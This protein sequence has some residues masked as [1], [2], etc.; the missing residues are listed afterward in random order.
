MKQGK[1]EQAPFEFKIDLFDFIE[2]INYIFEYKETDDKGRYLYWD[3]FKY[4]VKEGDNPAIAWWAT[5]F[6][7]VSKIK[8]LPLK[9]KENKEFCF[10]IPDALQAKLYQIMQKANQGIVP[11]DSIKRQYLISSLVIEEAIS[12]SQLEGAVT[13]RKVAKDMLVKERK[14]KSEDEWMILNNYMLLK[15]AKKTKNDNLSIGL[16]REFHQ[17]ATQHT[18][19]NKVVAGE[20]RVT[21][22][23]V[24]TDG[25]EVIFEPPS[26]DEIDI[27]LQELCDFA[28]KNHHEDNL[29]EFINPIVK[30]IILHFMIGYIHP[31]NDGNGRVART[32]FY[33]YM[34]KN[35]FDYFEY[36]SISSL[37]KVAPKK[38]ALSY[39]YSE[40]DDNDMTYFIAYQ[41]DIII[42]AIE[43]LL[44]YLQT[45][46]NDF[47][48]LLDIFKQSK[49]N[50]MLNFIQKNIITKAIKESGKVFMAKEI[51]NEYDVSQ[52]SARK[53]LNEL[54]KHK[55]LF[56]SKLGKTIIYIATNDIKNRLTQE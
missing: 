56:T 2:N 4:H 9:D 39:L 8:I 29:K 3:K 30:A 6:N 42:R 40:S 21:D 13:T 35:G 18:T 22:D 28:N 16:I 48:K 14:P 53:Y 55:L 19:H 25:F 10:S 44:N 52:N 15:E 45:K 24:I 23:I 27:R 17:I 43:E 33:W 37:L 51:A 36:I 41:L 54:A 32:L 31:F 46:S 12:S 7:R 1:I 20:L 47:E 11:H 49:Y 5:K 50:N 34:L 26:Y 38:Y